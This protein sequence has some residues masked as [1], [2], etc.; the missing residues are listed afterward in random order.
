MVCSETAVQFLISEVLFP[1]LL[2]LSFKQIAFLNISSADVVMHLFSPLTW[3]H[4]WNNAALQS[5]L[6]T[7]ILFVKIN[8]RYGNAIFQVELHAQFKSGYFMHMT[9]SKYYY[10]K[11]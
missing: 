9:Q 4:Y 6:L 5:G 3:Q 10:W 11:A 1:L 7:K 8:R 2:S